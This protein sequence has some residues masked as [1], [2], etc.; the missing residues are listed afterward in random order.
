MLK[1]ER[2]LYGLVRQCHELNLSSGDSIFAKIVPL[3]HLKCKVI[4]LGNVNIS[5]TPHYKY[6]KKER[7]FLDNYFHNEKNNLELYLKKNFPDKYEA[8]LEF[9]EHLLSDDSGYLSDQYKESAILVDAEGGIIDGNL[10][11]ARLQS[12]GATHAAVV[13]LR[14]DEDNYSRASL[15]FDRNASTVNDEIASYLAKAKDSFKEWYS[16]LELGP[17]KLPKRAYP[18][19][20]DVWE[21]DDGEGLRNWQSAIRHV[22]PDVKGKKILDIGCNIGL[23][24]LELA[25]M[26]ASVCGVD[27]GPLVFQPNNHLLGNQSVPNQAYAIRNIYEAFY[28]ER[29]TNV[30]FAEIDLMEFDFSN[31]NCELFFSCRVLYHLGKNKMEEIIN[32]ISKTTPEILLQSNEGHSGKLGKIASMEFHKKLLNKCGYKIKTEWAP[33]GANHPVVYAVK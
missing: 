15:G 24:S 17:Y 33:I 29:F 32:T 22:V 21:F 12:L 9:A 2:N 3:K 23:F 20:K 6:F 31:T 28:G 1:F 4:G 10:R 26:G 11:A 14:P 25:R 27:R 8:K 30:A 5:K 19:F 7:K 13:E 16:P 18:D